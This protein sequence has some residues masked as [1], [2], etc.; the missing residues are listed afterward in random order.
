M[1]Y[2]ILQEFPNE[3][4]LQDYGVA[5]SI[6]MPTHRVYT[7]QERDILVYKN[8]VKTID[9]LLEETLDKKT[10]ATLSGSLHSLE[11]DLDLWNESL[12][13]LAIFASLDFIVIYRLPE[14]V[15]PLATVGTK[16]HL[17]PIMQVFQTH[18]TVVLLTLNADRFRLYQAG[19]YGILPLELP[20]TIPTTLKEVLGT[21]HTDKYHTHGN[22]ASVSNRSSFHGHGGAPAAEELDQLRFFTRI[23]QFL[24]TY[25]AKTYPM[26]VILVALDHIQAEF[27]KHSTIATLES[28]GILYSFDDLDETELLRLL[29]ERAT[30]SFDATIEPLIERYH[31]LMNE[32]LSAPD[33]TKLHNALSEGRVD[34]LFITAEPNGHADHVNHILHQALAKGTDV[35]VLV[36]DK[37]PEPTIA[38]GLLRY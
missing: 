30:S 6:Y 7:E 22:Y 29:S 37:M 11:T 13:G 14:T 28:P 5:V 33:S 2:R 26:P 24:S 3:K 20:D 1:Q 27:M 9:T 8:L 16:F 35:F 17:V 21:Q 34:T 36:Q 31:T 32:G 18:N 19:P 12:E 38:A 10:A 4:L 23:N 15:T 25:V